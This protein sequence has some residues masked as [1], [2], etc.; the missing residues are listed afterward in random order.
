MSQI[1]TIE[2][3]ENISVHKCNKCHHF[4]SGCVYISNPCLRL[5]SAPVY[6]IPKNPDRCVKFNKEI[7]DNYPCADCISEREVINE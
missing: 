6:S 5:F 3:V 2:T 1:Q 4:E 7:I